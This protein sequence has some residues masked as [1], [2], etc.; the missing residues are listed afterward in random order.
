MFKTRSYTSWI[1]GLQLWWLTRK[2]ITLQIKVEFIID[3]VQFIN[4]FGNWL[5]N[6]LYRI[7]IMEWIDIVV[8]R[9]WSL[10]II[11]FFIIK[12]FSNTVSELILAIWWCSI[13]DDKTFGVE[14]W[15]MFL[16]SENTSLG[17]IKVARRINVM[18]LITLKFRNILY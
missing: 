8:G 3:S 13:N 6:I 10:I 7:F 1:S 12:I 11:D 18:G 5:K 9:H 2:N 16:F 17:W 4:C 15:T 14:D